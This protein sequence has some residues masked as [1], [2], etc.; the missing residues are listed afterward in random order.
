MANSPSPRREIISVDARYESET[1]KRRPISGDLDIEDASIDELLELRSRIDLRLPARSLR[2]VDIEKELVIQFLTVQGLQTRVLLDDEVAANQQAQVVNALTAALSNLSKLQNET[3][4]SERL[5]RVE[6]C[7][8]DALKL[9]PLEA[10]E[11]F[12]HKYEML[13]A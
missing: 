9:L 5:K 1:P 10:Q 4:T 3:Y 2:D 11:E 8:V 7:L 12:L 6:M 13:E